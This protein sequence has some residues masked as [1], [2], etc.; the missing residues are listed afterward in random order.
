MRNESAPVATVAAGAFA[1]DLARDAAFCV[2]CAPE[3]CGE[4]VAAVRE[5]SPRLLVL[6][7][8]L[9]GGDGFSVLE[10]LR[11]LPMPP[12]V[13]AV[14]PFKEDFWREK[15]LSL[16]A[17]IVIGQGDALAAP[18][19]EAADAL[20]PALARFRRAEREALI[21]ELLRAL[22]VRPELGGR[23]CL[24]RAVDLFV[25]GLPGTLTGRCYPAVA[26]EL[27]KTPGAVEKCVRLAIESAFLQA[28][29]E[30]LEALFGQSVSA[31]R[32]KPTNLEAIAMLAE[33]V[34]R[35][36]T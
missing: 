21:E 13:L 2:L 25:T 18:A 31:E 32:G 10:A 26:A 11:A 4:T 5:L 8:T 22:C 23:E 27:G 36:M 35:R 15:A 34:R 7:L 28:P 9:P 19:R 14:C 16:G 17:D 30:A 29:L 33:H 3:T 20:Q 6:S 12:R 24:A 1:Y